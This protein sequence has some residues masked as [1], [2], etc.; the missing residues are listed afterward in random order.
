MV[1]LLLHADMSGI[2]SSRRIAKAAR[3]RND[4]IMIVALDP[5]D[6]RTLAEFRTRHL[7]ALDALFLQV[8]KLC[9]AAGLAKLGHLA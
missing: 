5:P 9:E 4:F 6:V 1:A 3:E 7:K 8:L 2:P